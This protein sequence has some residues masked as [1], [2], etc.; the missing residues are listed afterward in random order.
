MERI[1]VC[2]DQ[3]ATLRCPKGRKLDIQY[4]NYGRL[5]GNVCGSVIFTKD[6]KEED[7]L[8]TVKADCEGKNECSLEA[9]NRKFGDPVGAQR[10]IWRLVMLSLKCL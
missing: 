4:A 5:K 3:K 9:N 2:E 8:E 10:N 1:R 7:S 6:C